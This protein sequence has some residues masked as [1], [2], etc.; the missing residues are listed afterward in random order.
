MLIGKSSTLY[1][2][3]YNEGY[4]LS[5]PDIDYEFGTEYSHVLIAGQSKNPQIVYDKILQK[6]KEMRVN[7]INLQDFERIKKKIYGDYATEYNN[8]ADIGRMLVADY[9]KGINSFEY[10]DKFDEVDVNYIKQILNELFVEEN[11]V[12]SVIKTYE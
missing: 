8:V 3:L 10:M 2:N 11:M 7:D 9:I 1:N 12:M 6:L 4:L 5:Q